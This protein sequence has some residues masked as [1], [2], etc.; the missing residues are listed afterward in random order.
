LQEER[1]RYEAVLSKLLAA[2]EVGN[3]VLATELLRVERLHHGSRLDKV[4]TWEQE[5]TFLAGG[6]PDLVEAYLEAVW[7]GFRGGDCI[8]ARAF[9]KLTTDGFVG[10]LVTAFIPIGVMTGSIPRCFPCA[11]DRLADILASSGVES[12]RRE[13]SHL[14]KLSDGSPRQPSTP[15]PGRSV[16]ARDQVWFAQ[17][18]PLGAKEIRT[19]GPTPLSRCGE[20]SLYFDPHELS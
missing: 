4:W 16:S 7:T 11:G 14:V 1:R 2:A 9:Q 20:A 12:L 13:N 5:A 3:K 6:R 19:L 18:S 8:G 15:G 10:G 17:D